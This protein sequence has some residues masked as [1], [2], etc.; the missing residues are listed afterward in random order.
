MK[1]WFA[2]I[3]TLVMVLTLSAC[4]AKEGTPAVKEETPAT[5]KGP[6]S[7]EIKWPERPIEIVIPYGAG[8]DTDFNARAYVEAWR[9][10][11]RGV[12]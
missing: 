12:A 10:F 5:E 11:P 7:E 1:K 4:G 2:M 9:A 3:L 6:Q 8:G